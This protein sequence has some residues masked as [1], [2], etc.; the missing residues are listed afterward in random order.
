MNARVEIIPG[1]TIATEDAAEARE[2]AKGLVD[3]LYKQARVYNRHAPGLVEDIQKFQDAA[4]LLDT[5][6]A[7]LVL[8]A[9]HPAM[10]AELIRWT[11]TA[12]EMPDPLSGELL[13]LWASS[14]EFPWVGYLDGD[15]WRSAEG[16]PFPL[17][18]V[19]HW[20]AM[21]KGP[22]PMP[23]IEARHEEEPQP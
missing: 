13:L 16:L 22:A 20:A 21:P 10:R 2:Q 8:I 5:F 18:S 1:L 23:A 17:D 15:F 11:A 19:T 4:T 14:D 9:P 3:W 7:G 12:A 6:Q